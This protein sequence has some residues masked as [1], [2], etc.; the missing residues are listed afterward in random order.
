MTIR[1]L[2]D[3]ACDIPL[4]EKMNNVDIMNFH[5]NIDGKDCEERVDYTM[6][7]FYEVLEK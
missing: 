5:I 7:E 1:I 6:E 3:S 4:N 2:T